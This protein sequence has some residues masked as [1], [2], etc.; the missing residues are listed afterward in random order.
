MKKSLGTLIFLLGTVSA[1]AQSNNDTSVSTDPARVAAVR[2]HAQKLQA[3][4]AGARVVGHG[5]ASKTHKHHGKRRGH[6][7]KKAG[8]KY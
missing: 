5:T 3:N 1:F 7:T 4:A 8:K 6:A 2:H